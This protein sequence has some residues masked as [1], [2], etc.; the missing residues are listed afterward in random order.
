V[1]NYYDGGEKK[2]NIYASIRVHSMRR[3]SSSPLVGNVI[4]LSFLQH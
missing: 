4:I 1:K 2:N 3:R